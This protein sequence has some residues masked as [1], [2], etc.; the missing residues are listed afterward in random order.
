M[1]AYEQYSLHVGG[2]YQSDNR[3]LMDGHVPVIHTFCGELSAK[4]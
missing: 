2:G 1:P 3:L 4:L